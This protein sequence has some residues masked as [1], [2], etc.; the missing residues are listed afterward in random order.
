MRDLW[1]YF[2]QQGTDGPVKIGVSQDPAKRLSYL[3]VGNPDPLHLIGAWQ[4]VER[5]DELELHAFLEGE[6]LRGEW[7]KPTRP[8]LEMATA[9]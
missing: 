3:Q 5:G 7:F 4:G 2:V 8:V 6:R 9:W 1:L